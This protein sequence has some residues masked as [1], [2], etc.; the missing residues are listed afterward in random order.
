[1]YPNKVVSNYTKRLGASLSRET[2]RRDGKKGRYGP[3][4]ARHESQ[5]P[6][7]LTVLSLLTVSSNRLVSATRLAV[8]YSDNLVRIHVENK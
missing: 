5:R 7:R 1:M 2:V 3:A 6:S 4:G 8:S